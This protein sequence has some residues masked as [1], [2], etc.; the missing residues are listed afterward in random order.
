[1]LQTASRRKFHDRGSV[2]EKLSLGPIHFAHPR[3]NKGIPTA[4]NC[5]IEYR[6]KDNLESGSQLGY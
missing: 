1:M 2:L 6:V 4:L 5:C 3:E